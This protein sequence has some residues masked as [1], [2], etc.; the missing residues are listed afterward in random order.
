MHA[1]KLLRIAVCRL[2]K[3]KSGSGAAC[4]IHD[5]VITKNSLA[6]VLGV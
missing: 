5:F 2:A 6:Y 3:T 1:L 4:L